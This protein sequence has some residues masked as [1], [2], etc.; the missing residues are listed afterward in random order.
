MKCSRSPDAGTAFPTC[1]PSARAG[2][3]A[4]CCLSVVC[5]CTDVCVRA[6][7][8]S[9]RSFVGVVS[10]LR[11]CV[12]LSR[13][14]VCHLSFSSFFLP[15]LTLFP[16]RMLR[17]GV[18]VW[19]CAA[20]K[21][22]GCSGRPRFRFPSL[23]KVGCA[24]SQVSSLFSFPLLVSCVVFFAAACL[25]LQGPPARCSDVGR[26][27]SS[28]FETLLLVGLLGRIHRT[29]SPPR[30]AMRAGGQGGRVSKTFLLCRRT[31][32]CFD[33]VSPSFQS[34]PEQGTKQR[35]DKRRCR[36]SNGLRLV[37]GTIGTRKKAKEGACVACG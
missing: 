10:V 11:R 13:V 26:A 30:A 17:E 35:N 37:Q 14:P 12:C 34:T 25:H 33:R 20:Q 36:F 32:A 21:S 1:G 24:P 22:V 23:G 19:R 6:C 5:Q 28:F 8:V 27:F 18:P 29:G 15:P 4:V 7:K 3:A 31:G 9:R 16:V 2:A